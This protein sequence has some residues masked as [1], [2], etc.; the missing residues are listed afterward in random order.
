VQTLTAANQ[1]YAVAARV[2]AASEGTLSWIRMLAVRADA[3]DDIRSAE[4]LPAITTS[5]PSPRTITTLEVPA[6]SEERDHLYL[7]SVLV[8]TDCAIPVTTRRPT[9]DIAG[10]TVAFDHAHESCGYRPSYGAFRLVRTS[11]AATYSTMLSSADGT[12]V[13]ALESVIVVLRA[14]R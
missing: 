14:A 11:S 9:F 7:S 8:D 13:E 1:T 3:F 10:Q 12:A 4:T 5:D 2:R 6:A